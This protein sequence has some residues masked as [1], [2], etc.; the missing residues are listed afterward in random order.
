MVTCEQP[1]PCGLAYLIRSVPL[2]ITTLAASV[3]A[4]YLHLHPRLLASKAVLSSWSLVVICAL[5]T[6]EKVQPELELQ[7]GTSSYHA[8]YVSLDRH[9]NDGYKSC[10]GLRIFSQA[11]SCNFWQ[12]L[13]RRVRALRSLLR[14]SL[15]SFL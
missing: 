4:R 7:A 14:L 10:R 9:S 3:E 5:I 2:P 8:L 1:S 13:G 12:S 11:L 6:G 15:L